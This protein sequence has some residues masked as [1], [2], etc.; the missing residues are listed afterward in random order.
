MIDFNINTILTTILTL[1]TGAGGVYLATEI[2]KRAKNIP[3]VSERSTLMLR[4]TAGV[5]SA[6]A[7]LIL[8]FLNQDLSAPDV[9]DAMVKV[10]EFGAVWLGAHAIHT[11]APEVET[12]E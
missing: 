12:P 10:L 11:N 8:G 3:A 7:V 5:F 6:A 9:Q 2:V 4:G 1:V